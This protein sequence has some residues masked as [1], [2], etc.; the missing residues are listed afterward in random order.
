LAILLALLYKNN[1]SAGYRPAL[2]LIRLT[3][4][5]EKSERFFGGG[6]LFEAIMGVHENHLGVVPRKFRGFVSG[7]GGDDD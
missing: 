5:G 6:G 1:R 3:R 7:I 2:I 4:N